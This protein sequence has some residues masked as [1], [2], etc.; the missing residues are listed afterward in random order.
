MLTQWS[1]GT[2]SAATDH[3]NLRRLIELVRERP[4]VQRMLTTEGMADGYLLTLP[5]K[6]AQDSPLV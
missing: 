4:A 3:D 5:P 2:A 1:L 6:R